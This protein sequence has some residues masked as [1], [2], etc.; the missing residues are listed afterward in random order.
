MQDHPNASDD[1]DGSKE[2]PFK[3]VLPGPFAELESG[4]VYSIDPRH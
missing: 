1:N 4:K 3:T 2:A